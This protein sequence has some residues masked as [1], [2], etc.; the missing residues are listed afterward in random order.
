MTASHLPF[1]K[2]TAKSQANCPVYSHQSKVRGA[3]SGC[4]FLKRLLGLNL[5]VHSKVSLASYSTAGLPEVRQDQ[6][7]CS[8]KC[9][10][11]WDQFNWQQASL[12]VNLQLPW[13]LPWQG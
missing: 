6:D 10:Q 12:V 1:L 3:A 2:V 11:A 4:S 8:G 9:P 5:G 7:L 13:S